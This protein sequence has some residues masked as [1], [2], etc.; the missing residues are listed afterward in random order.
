MN[1]P[2]KNKKPLSRSVMT[3]YLVNVAIQIGCFTFVIV[4]VAL[5]AGLWLDRVFT[6]NGV[7]VILLILASVPLTWV[8]IFWLVNRAKKQI[9]DAVPGSPQDIKT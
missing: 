8:F 1:Q 4:F 5:L 9:K 7:F 2:E 6:T 3:R